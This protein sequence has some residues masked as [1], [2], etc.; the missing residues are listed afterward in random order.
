MDLAGSE[1][2]G[3]T[4]AQGERLR[5]A[6]F[7]NKSLSALGDCIHAM[8][9]RSPHVPFRNSKLTYVLQVRAC[10]SWLFPSS[11]QSLA[12]AAQKDL[13]EFCLIADLCFACFESLSV[14]CHCKS[15]KVECVCEAHTS[16]SPNQC[17]LGVMPTAPHISSVSR[18]GHRACAGL[19]VWGQQDVDAGE[20]EPHRSRCWG[21]SML[22]GLCC[23]SEGGGAGPRQ[24]AH[25]GRGR[26]AGAQ[27]SA[28]RSASTGQP[29]CL[30]SRAVIGHC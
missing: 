27:G 17:N 30:L 13:P 14:H 18:A 6:Q 26:S 25:R 7:I 1:R 15:T 22:P 23:P 29:L 16:C 21:D 9:T 20:C 3:K 8:A 19:S 12:Y 4:E 28:G 11:S 2:V 24:E 10:S 5:E